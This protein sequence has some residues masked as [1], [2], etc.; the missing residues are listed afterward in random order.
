MG[1]GEIQK[2]R[3][4]LL[5]KKDMLQLVIMWKMMRKML[6]IQNRNRIA[7][8]WADPKKA[9]MMRKTHVFE[10]CLR[11]KVI[12]N[13]AWMLIGLYFLHL[14]LFSMT[15]SSK[16]S[17]VTFSLLRCAWKTY[18]KL[19]LC[20]SGSQERDFDFSQ[21]YLLSLKSFLP[22]WST[23]QC[24]RGTRLIWWYSSSW[25]WSTNRSTLSYPLGLKSILPYDLNA[26]CWRGTK[27][28]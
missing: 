14:A 9:Q 26:Q 10:R 5:S 13:G 25:W 6:L 16:I 23:S 11:K 27:I 20:Y 15:I 7:V 22:Q 1:K 28:I 2:T 24:W 8:S 4:F 19:I 18:S 12:G 3:N 21:G 17:S